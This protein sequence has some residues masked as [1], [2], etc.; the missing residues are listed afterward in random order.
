MKLLCGVQGLGQATQVRY[1]AQDRTPGWEVLSVNLRSDLLLVASCLDGSRNGRFE[2]EIG[3]PPVHFGCITQGRNRC[4][5]ANGKL[6]NR[7][8]LRQAGDNSIVCLPKTSGTVECDPDRGARVVSVLASPSFL[9]RYLVDDMDALPRPLR[10]A[11][12]GRPEQLLWRGKPSAKKSALLGRIMQFQAG[13]PVRR[14]LL[15][16]MV[17]EFMSMQL[18]E[19][20]RDQGGAPSPTRISKAEE[21]RLREA[22]RV[23]VADL[24]NPP[25]LEQLARAVGLSEKKLKYGF[26]QVFGVTVYEHF[27]NHRLERA[28]ELLDDDRLSISEVAYS[29]GYLNLSH[30]S[31]AFRQRFGL[32]PRDYLRRPRQT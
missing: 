4:A 26:R 7:E 18:D 32:N 9:A 17:L 25:G 14:L 23:L 30:F 13:S 8:L 24:E 19:C 22:R 31:A 10:L 2:F 5:Y 15:E 16:S 11:V 12:E 21:E 3:A 28:R 20:C 1:Q 29:V 6:K 27:R